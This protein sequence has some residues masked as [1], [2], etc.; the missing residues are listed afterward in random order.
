MKIYMDIT[1]KYLEQMA[2]IK[3]P[4]LKKMCLKKLVLL[5]LKLPQ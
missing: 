2:K 1:G 5:T 4:I 3:A